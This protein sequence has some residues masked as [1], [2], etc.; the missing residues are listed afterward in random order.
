VPVTLYG[1][2][3]VFTFDRDLELVDECYEC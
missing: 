1:E 3:R 2:A